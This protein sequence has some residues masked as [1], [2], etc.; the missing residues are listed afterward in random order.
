M[1]KEEA[2]LQTSEQISDIIA[3]E[4]K[5]ETSERL[6]D[7]IP[8]L[9]F[10]IKEIEKII[11]AK[12]NNFTQEILFAI[13]NSM[14]ALFKKYKLLQESNVI[15]SGTLKG[16]DLRALFNI[17]SNSKITGLL[18]IECD[19]NIYEFMLLRGKIIYAISSYR[20]AK[21]GDRIL[22]DLTEEEIKN[23]THETISE[24]LSKKITHFILEES[25]NTDLYLENLPNYN[26]EEFV[27]N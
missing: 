1:K 17:L 15:L 12:L 14:E 26:F 7:I 8:Q 25:Y 10:D 24:L 6:K 21:L 4:A 5:I 18:T 16:L 22:K 27:E 20:R 19:K 9:S 13:N 23:I 3:R 2:I 11:E